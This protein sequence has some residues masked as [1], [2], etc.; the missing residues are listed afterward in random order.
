MKYKNLRHT[1]GNVL[2]PLFLGGSI[3]LVYREEG[4]LMFRWVSFIGL[5]G[6]LRWLRLL[7]TNLS[8][9]PPDWVIFNLPNALWVYSFV[10]FMAILWSSSDCR[11]RWFWILLGASTAVMLEVGQFLRILGGTFDPADLVLCII[12]A[13]VALAILGPYMVP[14]RGGQNHEERVSLVFFSSRS[15]WVHHLGCR[16]YGIGRD[17]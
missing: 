17:R 10:A 12:A 4:L 13:V 11:W 7:V 3:Y 8:W 1:T 9:N 5:I 2:L 16:K 14:L 6:P 15:C